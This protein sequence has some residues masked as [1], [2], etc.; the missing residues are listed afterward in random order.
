M[1]IVII[2]QTSPI[3]R[4][5]Q[6]VV[7]LTQATALA[8][9]GASVSLFCRGQDCET[10]WVDGIRVNTFKYQRHP[11]AATNLILTVRS[12]RRA[13]RQHYGN[14]SI[15]VVHGHDYVL[16][17]GLLPILSKRS[18]TIFTVHDP[19]TYHQRM[20]GRIRNGPSLTRLLFEHIEQQVYARSDRIHVNSRFTKARLPQLGRKLAVVPNWT[21]TEKFSPPS[22]RSAVR[23]ELG[24]GGEFVIYSL[25]ALEVRMGL[26]NLLKGYHRFLETV[27]DASLYIGGTGPLLQE[28]EAMKSELSL[29]RMKLLGYVPDELLAKWYQAADVVVMPSLDGEGFG[30]PLIEAMACGTP[31]IGTPVCAIP[32]VLSGRPERILKDVTPEAISEGLLQ[33]HSDWTLGAINASSERQYVLQRY[34][35]AAVLPLFLQEYQKP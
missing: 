8:R 21:D 25:R 30:L 24:L 29:T 7:A 10:Q 1:N 19:L 13:W 32:E 20:L 33:V 14:D 28:L 26:G 2:C 11:N 6:Q 22:D 9:S 31:A 16:Y 15:D 18:R 4:R 34:S 12:A 3:H 23:H 35:E 27:P 17:W 5:G